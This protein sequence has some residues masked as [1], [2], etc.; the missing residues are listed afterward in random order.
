MDL[1]ISAQPVYAGEICLARGQAGTF[2]IAGEIC[3]PLG[4]L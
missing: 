2:G 1:G 3:L 4:Y